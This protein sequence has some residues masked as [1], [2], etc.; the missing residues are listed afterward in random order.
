MDSI[1]MTE[2]ENLV[3]RLET[4]AS[5]IY[6]QSWCIQDKLLWQ[7]NQESINWSNVQPTWLLPRINVAIGILEMSNNNI[8]A[9]LESII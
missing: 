8:A 5:K 9:L 3:D 6:H 7:I 4:M 1:K 2:L